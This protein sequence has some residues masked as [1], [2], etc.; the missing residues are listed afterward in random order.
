MGQVGGA[1]AETPRAVVLDN[2]PFFRDF[3]EVLLTHEGF[4]VTAPTDP[5]K[6]TAAYVASLRPQVVICEI[7]LPDRDG[8][9]LVSEMRRV[10]ELERA[11]IIVFS[12]LRA[13]ERALQAGADRFVLKPLMRERLLREIADAMKD[14]GNGRGQG[15]R[16]ASGRRSRSLT[17]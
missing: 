4:A 16:S 15:S 5:E 14:H 8:L 13:E 9:E 3:Q 1:D 7:L 6:F 2:D 12:V 11:T 17:P 10:P